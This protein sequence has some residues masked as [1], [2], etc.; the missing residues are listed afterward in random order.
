MDGQWVRK[1]YETGFMPDPMTQPW[2]PL[3]Q[4]N[5]PTMPPCVRCGASFAAHLDGACPVAE[6]WAPPPRP[7]W[8][9]R[10]PWLSGAILLVALL[11]G[12]GVGTTVHLNQVNRNTPNA[13]ACYAYWQISDNG[14]ALQ[15][16]PAAGGWHR[17][18]A[19]EPRITDQ[20]LS[21]SVKAFNVDL[22]YADLPDALSVATSI[23]ASCNTFGYGNPG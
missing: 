1:P 3:P 14:Y 19:M 11:S 15:R 22:V 23:E 5:Q 10:H 7:H 6:Y 20:A 18:R 8:P 12:I 4:W 21:T 2:L 17:L 13:K 16:P 9:R